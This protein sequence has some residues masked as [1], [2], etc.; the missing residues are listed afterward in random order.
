[1]EFA[2]SSQGRFS[3]RQSHIFL[4]TVPIF[5]SAKMGLSLCRL[6]IIETTI[7]RVHETHQLLPAVVHFICPANYLTF[8]L[9]VART[10][11]YG[12]I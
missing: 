5:V 9:A 1:M 6:G 11:F 10:E 7:C 2:K 12:I 3:K 4:G 8:S